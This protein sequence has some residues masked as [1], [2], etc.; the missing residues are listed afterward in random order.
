[1]VQNLSIS[2]NLT[3]CTYHVR[4]Q[5]DTIF[6]NLHDGK[7]RTIS[8]NTGRS[9]LENTLN[10]IEHDLVHVL[11]STRFKSYSEKRISSDNH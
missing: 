4:G 6:R 10:R 1:M 8:G 7:I 9:H 2:T 5:N 11:I 3:T